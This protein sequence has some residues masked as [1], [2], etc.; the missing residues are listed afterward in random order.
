MLQLYLRNIEH[1]KSG[2]SSINYQIK[3]LYLNL[4]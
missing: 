4:G 3:I 2:V 1:E